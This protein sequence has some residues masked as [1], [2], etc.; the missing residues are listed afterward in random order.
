MNLPND[1]V[2]IEESYRFCHDICRKFQSNFFKTFSR[3]PRSKCHAMCALYAFNRLTDDLADARFESDFE[4]YSIS[5]LTAEDAERI[6]FPFKQKRIRWWRSMFRL[7]LQ[8]DFTKEDERNC[9]N[10][11]PDT[12]LNLSAMAILPAFIDMVER[13]QIPRK[14]LFDVID[15]VEMDLT[16]NRYASFAELELYCERVASAVGL[17]CIHIWGFEGR[18]TPEQEKVFELARKVGIAYQL[19]N[20]LRDVK[21]DAALDRVYLPL[22]DIAAAGYSV[23]ELKQGIANPAFEKLMRQQLARA[24]DYYCASRELYVRLKP[25][26][27]KIF[28]LMTATYRAILKK[29][30]ADPAAVFTKRIRPGTFERFRLIAKWTCF[31]PKELFP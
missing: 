23:E 17:A 25:E 29:I 26:G 2:T 13:Y 9:L 12:D 5:S 11:H 31:A 19:T 20:I 3:L 7:A 10:I 15:G 8:H 18:G 1:L 22:E 24:E 14:H 4:G 27:K 16:K 6:A 21:E 28:G 30:A